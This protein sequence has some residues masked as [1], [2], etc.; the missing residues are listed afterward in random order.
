MVITKYRLPSTN[1]TSNSVPPRGFHWIYNFTKK[2]RRKSKKGMVLNEVSPFIE[3]KQSMKGH[4]RSKNEHKM[5]DYLSINKM[6]GDN[7]LNKVNDLMIGHKNTSRQIGD[8]EDRNDLYNRIFSHTH[9]EEVNEMVSSS[10]KKINTKKI[11]SKN[12]LESVQK[13]SKTTQKPSA[14]SQNHLEISKKPS[15]IPHRNSDLLQKTNS[16][17]PSFYNNPPKTALDLKGSYKHQKKPKNKTQVSHVFPLREKFFKPSSTDVSKHITKPRYNTYKNLMHLGVPDDIPN[18]RNK[19]VFIT[20]ADSFQKKFY[21]NHHSNLSMNNLHLNNNNNKNNNI[22]NQSV[23]H[24]STISPLEA[25]SLQDVERDMTDIKEE[26]TI[27]NYDGLNSFVLKKGFL[28]LDSNNVDLVFTTE[29]EIEWMVEETKVLCLSEKNCQTHKM[30]GFEIL[31]HNVKDKLDDIKNEFYL[32]LKK[33][34]LKNEIEKE[35]DKNKDQTINQH[36]SEDVFVQTLLEKS[37][38]QASEYVKKIAEKS[39]KNLL[40]TQPTCVKFSSCDELM[41][42]KRLENINQKFLDSIALKSFELLSN[43]TKPVF[44]KSFIT[45]CC[46]DFQILVVNAVDKIVEEVYE[47]LM[48]E[49]TQRFSKKFI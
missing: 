13:L 3:S 30:E 19:R 41:F 10:K 5:D 38:H 31:S 16:I 48:K 1:F 6:G 8:G 33:S 34:F 44:T 29:K 26:N 27:D 32:R 14:T 4:Y 9:E 42:K 37:Y 20:K 15:E 21:S 28:N 24:S 22:N 11:T 23:N 25:Q 18:G 43:D 49:K 12:R 39:Y 35:I 17:V 45:M 40:R 46:E 36:V 7:S 47:Q 2:I